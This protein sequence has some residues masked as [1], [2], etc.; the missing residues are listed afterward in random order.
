M[1][2]AGSC[3]S[4]TASIPRRRLAEQWIGR[5]LRRDEDALVFRR[6]SLCTR[7]DFEEA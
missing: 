5:S 3:P 7:G 6:V 2:A 1:A 4:G